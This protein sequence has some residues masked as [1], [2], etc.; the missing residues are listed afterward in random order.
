LKGASLGRTRVYLPFGIAMSRGGCT[1]QSG[2][3]RRRSF[4]VGWVD[5]ASLLP[6]KQWLSS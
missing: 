2:E 4:N 5:V 6:F 3:E 1:P